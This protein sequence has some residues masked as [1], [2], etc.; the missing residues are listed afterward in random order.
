M[1]RL[2]RLGAI[3]LCVIAATASPALAQTSAD[4][5]QPAPEA[6]EDASGPQEII[7][8]GSRIARRDY[9]S[10]SPITSVSESQL[11][12]TASPT[13]EE[14]LNQLPQFAGSAGAASGGV[15]S[16]TRA[17]QAS[18]NLR[19]LGPQRTLVLLD[20]RRMQPSGADGS[21]DLN[22]VPDALVESVEVITGGASAV[23]GSDAIAGVVNF[24]TKRNF[25]GILLEGDAGI[26]TYG[27]GATRSLRA[28]LGTDIGTR[29]NAVISF[30]YSDRDD[31]KGAA[32]DGRLGSRFAAALP[33]GTIRTAATNLPSQAA[34]DAIFAR[35]GVAPGSIARTNTIGFNN[36]GTLFSQNSPAANIRGLSEHEYLDGAGL[37][38]SGGEIFNIQIPLTRYSVFG[39]TYYELT[40]DIEAYAVGY[41]T[42][43]KAEISR[44]SP[45]TGGTGTIPISIPV[46]NPFIGSDL[47]Q[48]LASRP[49]PTAPFS[50]TKR[51][52]EVGASSERNEYDIFQVTGGLKGKLPSLG[53]S[54][55]AYASYG[56]A[57]QDQQIFGFA[58]QQA[59]TSLLQAA[60]G[61]ASLCAGGYNPFGITSI[62]DACRDYLLRYP[63]NH[64]ITRQT[65]VEASVQGGLAALPAG[66]LS[67]ALGAAYRRNSFRFDA[68][69]MVSSG[70]LINLPISNSTSG[71]TSVKEIYGE[72]LIP[73]IHDTP[74]IR[75]L[76]VNLGYRY[77][78]YN[79]VGSVST[80]KADVSWEVF[81]ALRL[82]GGYSR[83]IRAPNIGELYGAAGTVG[84]NLGAVGTIGSGDA[85][86]IRGAYRA[87]G[88]ADAAQVRALCLAQGVPAAI[89]DSYRNLDTLTTTRFSG[90]PD[91][92]EETADTYSI[93]AVLKSP[94]ASPFLSGI[95]LSVDYYNIKL[96]GAVGQITG[97]VAMSKCFNADGSN[98]TY[99][100]TNLYCSLITRLAGPGT[101]DV[102][103]TPLLNLGGYKTSGVDFQADWTIDW[104]ALGADRLGKLHLGTVVNYL[105]S[106]RIQNLPGAPFR[107]YGGTILN[108]QI[109]PLSTSLPKW[110]AVSWAQWTL[111]DFDLNFRWRHIG[112]MKNAN[113]VGT[114][115]TTRGVKAVD[116]F[117]LIGTLKVADD[118][119]FRLGVSNLTNVAA[120]Q[121]GVVPG[122]TDANTYDQLGRRFFVGAKARF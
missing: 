121:V 79:T 107:E 62:S 19:A 105:D 103:R 68:D 15:G 17:G 50:L 49:N 95:S 40:D 16:S 80:Y 114:T 24:R 99:S 26:T 88:Y 45:V 78:S 70:D 94:F 66:E 54:W 106:F 64:S 41:Y 90:N 69:P 92:S 2:S 67:F 42:N 63:E 113:N 116:Y 33:Q 12:A 76:D 38:Y 98:P 5:A 46:T 118:F 108:T 59:L 37:R 111:G 52:S 3:P 11:D 82:R 28:T 75:Q 112:A 8:T 73:I 60:D 102:I 14:A 109:D 104:G 55:D 22:T 7:V 120:P 101:I 6:A 61:G 119:D 4:G 25:S 81:D 23:Y 53:W 87:P 47:A 18:A 1:K 77:S 20:G 44:A 117:D 110:K 56:E 43:Y 9:T 97:Q 72:L 115:S 30:S 93:G 34:I 96:K 84:Q 57:R 71:S 39:K 32:R 10:N 29:G 35:Y 100:N 91:L 83:A 89:I 31:V 122:D 86:D 58:S 85:C 13:V 27:D 21:I 74:L 48:L 51:Y 36:D 65:V